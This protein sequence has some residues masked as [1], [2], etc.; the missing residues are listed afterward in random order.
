MVTL[1]HASEFLRPSSKYQLLHGHFNGLC[2]SL[3]RQELL[4]EETRQKL[5]ISTRFRQM[6]E[7]QNSLREMLEEEEEAKKNVEKQ[8]SVLQGQ[9]GT[10]QFFRSKINGDLKAPLTPPCSYP[11]L[12]DMK[13]KLDQEVSSLESAEESRKRLQ[14]EF[15]TVK[16]QLEER[17]AAYEKLERTKTRLQ[18][19]LDDLLVNQDGLRQLV[20]NM[21]RKQRKFDQVSRQSSLFK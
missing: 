17:E 1:V 9:V 13:K 19:E 6:E 10:P 2:L 12:G 5:S 14:R 18:Q 21:E 3:S 16:L 11:Q 7:E 20:N 15:D 4:Q 8:I